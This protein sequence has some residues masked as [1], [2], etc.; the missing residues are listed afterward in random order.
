MRPRWWR[1]LMARAESARERACGLR[2]RLAAR[3][4]RLRLAPLRG[5]R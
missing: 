1:G 2:A 4:R 5:R 3:E